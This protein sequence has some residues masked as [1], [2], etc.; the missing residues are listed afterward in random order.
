M[1][2]YLIHTEKRGATTS[3]FI[4][5]QVT[6]MFANDWQNKGGRWDLE[7]L[8]MELSAIRAS[9]AW[10]TINANVDPRAVGVAM[11]EG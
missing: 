3:A 11:I 5:S 1:D 10:S 4:H 7:G 8:K 6:A 9:A 2:A